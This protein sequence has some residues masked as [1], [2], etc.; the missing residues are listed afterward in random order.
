MP[1][2]RKKNLK[3]IFTSPETKTLGSSSRKAGPEFIEEMK[4]QQQNESFDQLPCSAHGDAALDQPFIQKTFGSFRK[5]IDEQAWLSLGLLIPFAGRNV[6]TY[7]G[8]ILFG[9]PDIRRQV[10]PDAR[11]SCA[12]FAGI[13]KA[14]FIDRIDFEESI[15]EAV[16]QVPK[17]IRRNTR[18][19]PK[20]AGLKREDISAYPVFA[21]REILVNSVTHCDYSLM[22]MRVMVAIFADRLEIQSP[23]ILPFG[24]TMKDF[25]SGV[26]KIRNRVVARTFKEIGLME[27]WGSGY[28]RIVNFCKENDYP[29]PKWQEVGPALR[30]TL[31][32]HPEVKENRPP[33]PPP[34]QRLLIT[35]KNDAGRKEIQEQLGIKNKKHFLESYLKPAIE[36]GVLE[37]TI[38]DKPNS[39]LQKYRLTAFGWQWLEEQKMRE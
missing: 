9:R 39:P 12:R 15:I 17:F 32:P 1:S 16:E 28:K 26:S 13:S 14:E 5:D 33:V 29:V 34:V 8:L 37:M 27:E 25:K 6:A 35:C 30:V 10:L 4:R 22:G 3:K 38:P 24:M 23:G 2:C 7:G 11:V 18:L 20:I 31:Y 21:V 36:Q 19:F